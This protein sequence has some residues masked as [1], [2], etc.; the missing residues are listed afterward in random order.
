MSKESDIAII[1]AGLVRPESDEE[2]NFWTR[3]KEAEKKVRK[4]ED[5]IERFFIEKA[6][7]I[8]KYNDPVVTS[9]LYNKNGFKDDIN[10]ARL[11]SDEELELLKDTIVTRKK[12]A[13]RINFPIIDFNTIQATVNDILTSK[14]T[15]G[16]I[17][18]RVGNDNERI[19]FA[20]MG[21]RLHKK[22]DIC[23]FCG[24]EIKNKVFDELNEFFSSAD[25]KTFQERIL[26]EIG[27]LNRMSY[28][29]S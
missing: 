11:I 27:N 24:N 28:N 7:S 15:K 5:E 8:K 19:K 18:N 22:G 16:D 12:I 25:I 10:K 1:E 20:Q 23:I 29:Q 13:P 6:A 17:I 21:L 14:V 9:P 3:E 4:T 26:S 2:T